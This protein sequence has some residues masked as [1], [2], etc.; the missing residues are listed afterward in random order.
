MG[1]MTERLILASASLTRARLLTMAG[2]KVEVAPATLD[3]AVVKRRFRAEGWSAADCALALAEAKALDTA[4][5]YDGALVIGA[6]QLLVS[7]GRWFDKPSDLA[8]MRAQLEV[9]RGRIHELITAVCVV[10]HRTRLWHA[11]RRPQLT[12]RG[13]S[14][15]FLDHYLAR[16]GAE[17]LG[18]V[19]AYRL[20]G[21]GVQLFSR[22]DRDYFTIL[23]LPVLELLGFLRDHGQVPT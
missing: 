20:E 21:R 23:G 2:L 11:V 15:A 3:E 17:V 22:I 14:D 7:E 16:E 19:G 12:M 13:F 10:Q 9:L 18:S 8:E 4:S 5:R 1:W 6:D